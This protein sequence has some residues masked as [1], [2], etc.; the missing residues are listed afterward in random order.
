MT[1]RL[2]NMMFDSHGKQYITVAI[3]SDFREAYDSL[4]DEEV[5]I[6]IKKHRK[7]RSLSA[8]SYAWILI[9]KLA[10]KMQKSKDE[11]Y[12][13][14]IKH[15]GGV[16]EIVCVRAETSDRFR[17]IWESK[18]MGWQTDIMPS[19]ISGCVNVVLYYGSSTYDS[20]QMADLIALLIQDCESLGIPTLT[21]REIAE[22]ESTLGRKIEL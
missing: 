19:K 13:N 18:G 6:E 1:G 11:I 14:A 16:S 20:K 21:P 10:E 15:I 7:K 12:K 8:N 3:E 2:T 17:E 22:L 5:D 4:K 9:D